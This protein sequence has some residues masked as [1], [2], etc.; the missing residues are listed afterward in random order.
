M[1]FEWDEAKNSAN[2]RKHGFD[3]EDAHEVFD[4]PLLARLDQRED[5]GEGRW[6]GIGL[7]RGCVVVIV[8]TEREPDVIRIISL[9]KA[10]SNERR[11]FQKAIQD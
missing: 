2:V 10:S 11:A 6:Q 5:Y 9:R 7:L 4:S 1:R 8:F 3:F